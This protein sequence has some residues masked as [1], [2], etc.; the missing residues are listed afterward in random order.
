MNCVHNFNKEI[1]F[2]KLIP[3]RLVINWY[4]IKKE[5]NKKPDDEILILTLVWNLLNR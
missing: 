3:R 5:V 2:L 1:I 4:K